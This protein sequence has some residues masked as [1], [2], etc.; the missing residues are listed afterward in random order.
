MSTDPVYLNALLL[1]YGPQRIRRLLRQFGSVEAA[2][3]RRPDDGK[4]L[5]RRENIDPQEKYSQLVQNGVELIAIDDAN[6]P[7][8]LRQIYS[9]PLG[10]Y[11][12]GNAELLNHPALAVVGTRAPS[13]YGKET[14]PAIIEELVLSGFLIVSGL[15]QG[16]DAVAHAATLKAGGETVAVLGCGLHEVFPLINRPLGEK[17]I[18]SGGAIISE[19]PLGMPPFKQHFPARNRIIAGLALGTFVVESRLPGG[20]L[21]TAKHALEANR[22]VFA[23]PGP[24]NLLSSQGTNNLIRQ[25]AKLVQSAQDILEELALPLNRRAL[26]DTTNELAAD[27][28][29]II[30]LLETEPLHIDTII[31]TVKLKPSIVNSL[32]TSLELKGVVKNTGGNIYARII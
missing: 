1:T 8:L 9:P 10:L 18:A 3:E 25:G 16:I 26:T 5:I 21:I 30:D 12:K 32:M 29:A 28:K 20:A 23:L 11:I 6:Y 22:E 7:E 27:E 2:W 4:L 24:I 19:Y 13:S 15:A 31:K 14:L 17:I